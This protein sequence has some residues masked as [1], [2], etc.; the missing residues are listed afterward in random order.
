M[1]HRLLE[2]TV[3]D[4]RDE[5]VCQ[6]ALV[7]DNPAIHID[8]IDRPIGP[9]DDLHGAEAFIGRS[10]K[11]LTGYGRLPRHDAVLLRE[12]D[13]LHDVGS[14][15]RDEG[16]TAESRAKEI[17]PINERAARRGGFRQ[18]AVGA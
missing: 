9:V 7:L 6:E 2:F 11:F 14:G 1:V 16:I 13:T 4:V 3:L 8:D 12:H 5:V 15:L 10:Q 18:R 17:T